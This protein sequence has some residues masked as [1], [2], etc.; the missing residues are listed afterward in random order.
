MSA[1]QQGPGN[2][3]DARKRLEAEYRAAAFDTDAEAE[4][5]EWIESQP[6]E[7]LG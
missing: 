1:E 6:D 5:M 7:A 3:S 4:A 2:V